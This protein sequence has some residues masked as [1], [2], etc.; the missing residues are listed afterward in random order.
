M[1][2]G[3]EGDEDMALLNILLPHRPE[4]LWQCLPARNAMC[5][6]LCR[7]LLVQTRTTMVAS[8]VRS[9][10]T[11]KARKCRIE[12]DAVLCAHGGSSREMHNPGQADIA[13]RRSASTSSGRLFTPV[14]GLSCAL[15]RQGF[16]CA[17]RQYSSC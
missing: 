6:P 16:C 10:L 9:S 11:R 17:R 2:C 15:T 13:L 12:H 1:L 14:A 7:A 5:P 3:A 8:L 4:G